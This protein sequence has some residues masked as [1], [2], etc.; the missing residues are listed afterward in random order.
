MPLHEISRHIRNIFLL[1]GIAFSISGFSWKQRRGR[2]SF[3][4]VVMLALTLIFF[5]QET[6][7]MMSDI[8]LSMA[9]VIAI[10]VSLYEIWISEES[11]DD[12]A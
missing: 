6:G 8:M 12:R 5:R 11:E 2:K 1:L 3:G 7:K 4:I 10:G 9:A